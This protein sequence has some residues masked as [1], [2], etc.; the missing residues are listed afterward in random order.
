MTADLSNDKEAE[1]LVDETIKAYG[2][3]DILV[4]NAGV[5]AYVAID[6][7]DFIKIFDQ[8]HKID[9]RAPALLNHLSVPY[10]KQ[11][12]GTII[13]VSSDAG[14]HP[15]CSVWLFSKIDL[16]IR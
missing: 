10:L 16:L 3:L 15:V 13:H 9:L 5:G 12:N 1:R 4:N 2:K 11:T 8:V 7:T 6:S 14:H